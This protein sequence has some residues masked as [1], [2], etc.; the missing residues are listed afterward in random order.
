MRT[1]P[2]IDSTGTAGDYVLVNA[3][4]VHACTSIPSF[5]KSTITSDG[6]CA[7][8]TLLGYS[9]GNGTAGNVAQLVS[10]GGGAWTDDFLGLDAEL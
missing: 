9:T 2:S 1:S 10:L 7:I 4:A 5:S 6:S 8:V 3:N